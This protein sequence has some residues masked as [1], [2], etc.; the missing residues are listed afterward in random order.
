MVKDIVIDQY[1]SFIKP[2]LKQNGFKK[3]G[4][5]WA[6]EKENIRTEFQIQFSTSNIGDIGKFTMNID[7][8][9]EIIDT[10]W[11]KFSETKKISFNIRSG[12]II[13]GNDKWYRINSF[14]DNEIDDAIFDFKRNI[15]PYLENAISLEG[16]IKYHGKYLNP[17]VA[18]AYALL[19]KSECAI[20][21]INKII[22]EKSRSERNFA[23]IDYLESIKKIITKNCIGI[24][25]I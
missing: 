8:V 23:Y 17:N 13:S 18:I 16:I 21:I 6:R 7:V 15:I 4:F 9:Y 19:G 1:V 24:D 10:N 5:V 20:N 2:I 14:D 3:S 12:S 25:F 22:S 11:N